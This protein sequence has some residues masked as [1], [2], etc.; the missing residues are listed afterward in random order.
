MEK[1]DL[2]NFLQ[3][4]KEVNREYKE[5][6]NVI[7]RENEFYISYQVSG[8]Y[9]YPFIYNYRN[10]DEYKFRGYIFAPRPHHHITAELSKNY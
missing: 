1:T 8:K 2:N 4:I 6:V 3:K 7:E 10:L 9:C 5:K